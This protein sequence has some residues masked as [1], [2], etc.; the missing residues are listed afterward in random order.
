MQ[1]DWI[2]I[3]YYPQDKWTEIWGVTS[4]EHKL[5]IVFDALKDIAVWHAV[6]DF[7]IHTAWRHFIFRCIY[8]Y[9][10]TLVYAYANTH[11]Y[12]HVYMYEREHARAPSN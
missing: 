10:N 2:R 9:A 5:V 4:Y 6:E 1:V 11:I 3:Q 7:G 8:K 12:K